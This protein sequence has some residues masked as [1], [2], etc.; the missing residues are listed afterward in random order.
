MHFAH[1]IGIRAVTRFAIFSTARI[2]LC[3]G[4]DQ[5]T[6]ALAQLST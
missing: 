3:E 4:V 6:L 1:R 2:A 5:R